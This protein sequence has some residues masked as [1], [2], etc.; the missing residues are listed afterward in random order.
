MQ[1]AALDRLT[2]LLQRRVDAGA[3][4]PAETARAQVAADLV[5]SERERARAA[6]AIHRRELAA[7][8]GANQPD[9]N[10]A[11]G[12][13]SR[14]VSPPSFRVILA[15]LDGNPQLIRWTAVRA[16]RDAELLAAR[17]NQFPTFA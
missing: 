8:M 7:L 5:K 1:I 11:L 10:Q 13:L 17:L 4:S 3:S 16:Q 2:P 9:F 6:L 14:T 15:S 12:N